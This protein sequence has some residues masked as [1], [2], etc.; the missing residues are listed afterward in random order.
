MGFKRRVRKGRAEGEQRGRPVSQEVP[1]CLEKE[2]WQFPAPS[3]GLSPSS[4]CSSIHPPRLT[5]PTSLRS[6]VALWWSAGWWW[7]PPRVLTLRRFH[8]CGP[9]LVI[10]LGLFSAEKGLSL[11][12][13]D[14]SFVSSDTEG[15]PPPP[16]PPPP[17]SPGCS[18]HGGWCFGSE[19]HA[20]FNDC[21]TLDA[22]CLR[23]AISSKMHISIPHQH[24]TSLCWRLMEGFIPK[25]P[26]ICLGD[27]LVQ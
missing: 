18:S 6:H 22:P 1:P 10:L 9:C 27:K 11:S 8:P 24:T 16:P 25:L 15:P 23:S 5:P 17:P 12:G 20:I 19:L 26:N 2:I 4:V 3:R 13:S 7:T 14:P 21:D